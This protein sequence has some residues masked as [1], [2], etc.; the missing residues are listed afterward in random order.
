M[1]TRYSQSAT[2]PG[3]DNIAQNRERAT[4]THS[5]AVRRRHSRRRQR[6]LRHRAA[7]RAARPVGGPDREGQARRHLPAPRLHPDQG[8]A[9]R[10]RDRR[11]DPR[12]GAVR[13][14]GR[15]RRHRHG[16]RQ[17]LQGRR[18]RPACTRDCRAWSA[19][20]KGS[21]TSRAPASWSAPTT[22]EVDG[23]ASY[24][25]RNVVL[26]TGSYSQDPAR[27]SRST[28]SGSSPPSTP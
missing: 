12:V 22:V 10:R 11:P 7:S 3:P 8:A 2:D 5:G 21:P 27:A 14:Q 9:A 6:R 15:A 26:A 13:H 24:T 25:G 19:R 20:A 23:P 17:R 4:M 1:T 28:A 18:G 16:R